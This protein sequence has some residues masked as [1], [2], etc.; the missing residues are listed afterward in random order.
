MSSL[1][2]LF[3]LHSLVHQQTLPI[4][5]LNQCLGW[6]RASLDQIHLKAIVKR[7]DLTLHAWGDNVRTIFLLDLSIL[8]D[9]LITDLEV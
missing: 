3:P 2:K 8:P 9:D 5:K 7:N 4:F 6:H 1:S